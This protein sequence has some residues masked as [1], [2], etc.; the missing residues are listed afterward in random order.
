MFFSWNFCAPD[1]EA[2]K[3]KTASGIRISSKGTILEHQQ[4]RCRNFKPDFDLNATSI[5][6]NSKHESCRAF[7]GIP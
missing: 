6:Q 7:S 4:C 1:L 5:S 2:F 3:I